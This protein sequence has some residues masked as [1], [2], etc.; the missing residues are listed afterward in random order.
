MTHKIEESASI[1]LPLARKALAR[2][3]IELIRDELNELL[4]VFRIN[5]DPAYRIT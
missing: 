4:H 3:D 2:G 1:V 5:L